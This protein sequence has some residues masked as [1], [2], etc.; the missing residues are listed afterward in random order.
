[1]HDKTVLLAKTKL[2]TVECLISEAL[3]N[4]YIND[5]KFVSV[6]NVLRGNYEMKEGIKNTAEY[7]I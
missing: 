5:D 1:M 3:T 4:L 2:N 6:N 7:T